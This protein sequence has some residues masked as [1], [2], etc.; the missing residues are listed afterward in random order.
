M[1]RSYFNLYSAF[2]RGT[3]LP[4]QPAG[5]YRPKSLDEALNQLMQPNTVPL[6]GGTRLLATEEGVDA[7]VIDLQD[8]GLATIDWNPAGDH[9]NIGAMVRLVE[10]DEFLAALP[11]QADPGSLLRQAIHRA[12]PN[13]YRNAATLGGLIASR[14]PDSELLAALLVL[15]T[16]IELRLPTADT[17]SLAAYL[18][19]ADRPVGLITQVTIPWPAGKGAS[20]RVAR[21]PAD[22]PIVSVTIWTPAGDTPRLAATG[23]NMR[24]V[25]LF[26]AEAILPGSLSDENIDTAANEARAATD[27]PGDFRG[28]AAYRAEMVAVLTR[29][30][31]RGA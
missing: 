3:I 24:P 18:Q 10:L 26:N 28:D 27:H 1:V 15:G 21:T 25:R 30:V 17:M 14:L 5:Y 12:G 7:A 2:R 6:A 29:R 9:L 16:F 23:I 31:L 20:E 13:T 4:K 22:Q 19:S 8:T 11:A